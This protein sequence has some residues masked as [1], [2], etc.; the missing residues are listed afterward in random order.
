MRKN[1]IFLLLLASLGI[2]AIVGNSP[3]LWGKSKKDTY[4]DVIENI[5]LFGKVYEQ[6]FDRYIEEIDPERFSRAGIQGMLDQLDPYTVYLEPE[7]Q[8]EL[9]IMTRGKYYGVG[10]RISIRNGWPTVSD[11]PFPNSPAF[12]AGIREG[13][14]IIKIDGKAT[15]NEGLSETAS[16]L[17][18]KTRGS[19]V[20]IEIQRVG[21]AKPIVFRLVRDEIV[22]SDIEYSGFVQPGIGLVK[23][24]RFNRGA[25]EQ[26]RDAV[27]R[28]L[29]Q[30]M[31]AVI[32]DLRNDP[33][34][35]LDVA[36][37]VADIFVDKG[38]LVVYTEGRWEN[39]RQDYRAESNPIVGDMPLVVLINAGSA[40]ASEIVAGAIQDLDRGIIIGTESFGKGLVQTVVP[41]DRRGEHQLKL[42]TAQY[43]MPSGRLIQKP[44]IFE[45]GANSI[46]INRR[47]AETEEG[48]EDKKKEEAKPQEK[49]YTRNGRVVLGGGGIR[50][51]VMVENEHRKA[52]QFVLELLRQSMFFNYSLTFLSENPDIDRNFNVTEKTVNDF[53]D[54]I[55]EKEFDFE[56]DG[57]SELQ[58]LEKIAKKEGYFD[59]IEASVNNIY[60]QFNSV[61]EMER[62][63]SKDQV[64]LILK[65]EIIGKKFGSDA[66]YESMFASDSVLIKACDVLKDP[67]QY[68]EI[69]NKNIAQN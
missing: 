4:R 34:G 64:E 45:R 19:E 27:E 66:S 42:T 53:F 9:E 35:L 39:S 51:D 28:L 58:S 14:Q 6:V 43:F 36:V 55:K 25:D 52:T 8:D 10:M 54:F 41:I 62:Q 20:V 44:D 26:V 29:D 57:Y 5:Q 22:V 37:S 15:K 1:N 40:S 16:R 13:D 69:L 46:F 65:R 12:R 49:Y 47:D 56:P 59:K 63:K 61:K 48:E 3:D 67:V 23:L 11:Q 50:P 18:G 30:G 32:L 21:E 17:R 24:S 68:R 7:G 2:L 60:D 38:E 31:E 33:G